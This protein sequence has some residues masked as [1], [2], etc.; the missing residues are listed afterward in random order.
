MIGEFRWSDS[1][2]VSDLNVPGTA[3]QCQLNNSAGNWNPVVTDMHID[4]GHEWIPCDTMKSPGKL[5]SVTLEQPPDSNRAAGQW[6]NAAD[7]NRQKRDTG[8]VDTDHCQK[9]AVEDD[10]NPVAVR[11]PAS[12]LHCIALD[13]TFCAQRTCLARGLQSANNVSD[14]P[15]PGREVPS[16]QGLVVTCFSM[17]TQDKCVQPQ[18][19]HMSLPMTKLLN[20]P[21]PEMLY[22]A[23]LRV[24]TSE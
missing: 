2:S 1:G 11:E 15:A 24:M 10:Q 8:A 16:G 7:L 6:N 20:S 12:E 18:R 19:S 5:R 3:D 14:S 13:L 21:T 17:S 9:R 22:G 23:A 4:S